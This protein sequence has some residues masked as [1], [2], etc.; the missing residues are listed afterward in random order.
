MATKNPDAIFTTMNMCAI[1]YMVGYFKKSFYIQ[2][3]VRMMMWT[4]S[5]LRA[6]FCLVEN[7]GLALA[8]GPPFK[9]P[10]VNYIKPI[11]FQMKN[12]VVGG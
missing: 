1:Y 2:L 4:L 5:F 6:N 9:K 3:L 8:R 7:G 10:Y 12:G 11:L